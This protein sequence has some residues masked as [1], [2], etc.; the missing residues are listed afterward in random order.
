MEYLK[1]YIFILILIIILCSINK[2]NIEMFQNNEILIKQ[3]ISKFKDVDCQITQQNQTVI[4]NEII[5]RNQSCNIL[6]FG[7]GH[8]SIIYE[9][10]NNGYTLFIEDD[11]EWIDKNKN[12][13]ENIYY[14]NYPTKMATSLP[15][16][17]EYLTNIK[18]PQ[19][20]KETKWD[21]ILVD[22]PIGYGAGP[23]RSLPIYWSNILKNNNTTLI[24]D[25]VTRP[26]ESTYIKYFIDDEI[27]M[28][29]YNVIFHKDRFGMKFYIPNKY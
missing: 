9:S 5:K 8:D 22:G 14:Y 26:V 2:Y 21:I 18:I 28:N 29:D 4:L 1:L 27:T 13:I 10:V 17:L 11:Q 20:I 7:L 19:K 25:D 24:F 3:Y 6:V 16:N 12:I 15:I 23:G